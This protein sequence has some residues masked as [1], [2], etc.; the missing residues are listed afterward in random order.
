MRL[1]KVLYVT[2][3]I[4]DFLA[5]SLLHGLRSL[6]GTNVVDYPRCRFLDESLDD[7]TKQRMHG[8]GFTLYGRMPDS[9]GDAVDRE[10]VWER[11]AAGEFELVI[12]SS[13]WRQ[14]EQLVVHR[15]ALCR[16]RTVLIDGED[17]PRYFPWS[18]AAVARGC[19]EW[20]SMALASRGMRRFSRE[21]TACWTPESGKRTVG[22]RMSHLAGRILSAVAPPSPI[23]FSI[24]EEL[25]VSSVPAKSRLF[26]D[27]VVDR[28]TCRF[29]DRASESPPYAS[30]LEYFRGI[31]RSRFA[32]TC[33]RAGWDC[34]RHYEIAACGCVP[35]FRFL[36]RK[37]PE[38]APHGLADG[39]NCL[40]YSEPLAMLDRVAAMSDEE[41]RCLALGAIAWAREN[42]T[43]QRARRLLSSLGFPLP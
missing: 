10:H 38:C 3:P 16:S 20:M 6:L 9:Q 23:S 19:R 28:E 2:A 15:H 30:E 36:D 21:R 40:A 43:V 27:H 25:V 22:S 24:P 39:V 12:F 34:M 18:G 33:K 37:P 1:P 41:Y 4:N 31:A 35:C 32:V 13:I 8:R 7:E 26:F 5:D 29:I 14:H 11:A 17:L 42:T